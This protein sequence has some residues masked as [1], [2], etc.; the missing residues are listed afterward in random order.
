[1]KVFTCVPPGVPG[2]TAKSASKVH[3]S[4]GASAVPTWQSPS[5]ARVPNLSSCRLVIV[6][7]TV[8]LLV[9][10]KVKVTLPPVSG[11]VVGLATL[12]TMMLG[13]TSV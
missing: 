1:M 13:N 10:V 8:P 12:S 2:G 7:P 3:D 5:P 6:T 9:T 11:T 4:A